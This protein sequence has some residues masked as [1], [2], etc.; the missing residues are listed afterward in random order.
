MT[1]ATAMARATIRETAPVIRCMLSTLGLDSPDRQRGVLAS[2]FEGRPLQDRPDLLAI[3]L[4]GRKG[5]GNRSD[6]DPAFPWP[7]GRRRRLR[8]RHRFLTHSRRSRS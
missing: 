2:C 8:I 1:A 7:E 6:A 5:I 4:A 3:E